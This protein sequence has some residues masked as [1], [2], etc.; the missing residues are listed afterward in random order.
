MSKFDIERF[1]RIQYQDLS[2]DVFNL[3]AQDKMFWLKAIFALFSAVLCT[4]TGIIGKYGILV[5]VLIYLVTYPVEVFVLKINP[6][7]VG[8]PLRMIL[9]GLITYLFIFT[10]VSGLILSLTY[11][12]A[13]L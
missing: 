12:W 13:L 11:N 10:C 7:D 5:T 6:S 4:V 8:G 1:A 2:E 3:N 9:S